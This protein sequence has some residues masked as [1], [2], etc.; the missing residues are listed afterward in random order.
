MGVGSWPKALDVKAF[1]SVVSAADCMDRISRSWY[2]EREES[3]IC[4]GGNVCLQ[5]RSYGQYPI[6]TAQ[7]GIGGISGGCCV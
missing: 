5:Y 7:C 6:L 1:Q 4:G 3:G 2:S